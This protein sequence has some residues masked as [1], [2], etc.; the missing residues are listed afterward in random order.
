MAGEEADQDNALTKVARTVGSA[1]GTVTAKV[2]D[3]VGSKAD[4][5]STPHPKADKESSDASS[6]TEKS[7]PKTVKDSAKEPPKKS[8]ARKTTSDH[9]NRATAQKKARRAKHHRKLGR[10]TRG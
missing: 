1:L 10:K 3:V 2:S 5:D 9:K 7:A 6:K 8:V 4:D